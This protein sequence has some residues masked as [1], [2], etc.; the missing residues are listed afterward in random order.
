MTTRSSSPS[1]AERWVLLLTSI[2]SLMVALDV[3]VVSTALSSIRHDFGASIGALEW[4]V[5]AYTLTFAVLLLTGS[6]LGDRFGRRRM[7]AGGLALFAASSA[8]CAL[9][10]DAGML[11]AFRAVQGSAA[12]LVAPLSLSILTSAIAPARRG[13]AFGI[14][15]AITGVAVLA[16]PVVGGAVTQ[17]LAWQWVF[18]IN[19]PIGLIAIGFVLA[20]LPESRG[21]RERPDLRGLGLV[22]LA[23]LGIVFGLVRSSSVGWGSP[24]VV[25]ALAG[26]TVFAVGFVRAELATA[27]PML[28]MRLFA[29][30]S[31]SAGGVA[32]FLHTC[33]LFSAVFFMAQ[34]QQVAQHQ[35]PLSSG[36]RLLAWTGTV[37]VVAPLSGSLIGRIGV[38]TLIVG[39]LVLQAT[40]M[41]WV[42]LVARAGMPYWEMIAPLV[43]A[44]IGGAAVIPALQSAVVGG[45]APRDIGKSSGTFTMLRQL[46][47][48]FGVAIC[49]AVFTHFGGYASA[50]AFAAGFSP[51]IAA[52]AGFSLAGA[53]VA[54]FVPGRAV[55]RVP[56]VAEATA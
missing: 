20:R 1:T 18:W 21:P 38:R 37:F 53:A 55:R 9:A 27:E 16:G 3:L 45:A 33:A 48:V 26:G 47:G 28:P 40:G 22:T 24:Q 49:A 35:D 44:G 6:A 50:H 34:F 46:G 31:F 2:A 5:N 42:A 17:G 14:Y 39:S 30:R 51:A 23:A 15:G 4:T 54:L 11:I 29:S 8:A 10:P 52:S 41:V 13:W 36:L 43:L 19:V 32:C 25:G 56:A 12:A 7:F